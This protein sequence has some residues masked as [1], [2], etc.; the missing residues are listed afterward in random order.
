MTLLEFNLWRD[1]I[2][3]RCGLWF[4]DSRAHLLRTAVLERMKS[5]RMTSVLEYRQFVEFHPEGTTEW[6]DLQERLLNHETSFFRDRSAFDALTGLVLPT[7]FAEELNPEPQHRFVWS[8]GCSTGAE[9]Y[10][11]AMTL[12]EAM[13][14]SSGQ[15]LVTGSDLSREALGRARRGWYRSSELHGI[16]SG[17]R[18]KYLMPSRQGLEAGFAMVPAVQA[19]TRFLRFGLA[20]PEFPVP[21]QDVIFCRNVLIYLDGSMR[22]AVVRRLAR[23][24]KPGGWLFLGPADAVG[25]VLPDLELMP[26][27]GAVIYRN[28]RSS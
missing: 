23:Y 2:R 10:S 22:D 18:A 21:L 14:A 17:F 19:V 1:F 25:L 28:T 8:A 7:W 15:L 9:V 26:H 4:T 20:D 11:L 5:R 16:S 3:T 27:E 13:P 24:L 6:D 12:L